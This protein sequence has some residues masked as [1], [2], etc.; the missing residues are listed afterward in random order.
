MDKGRQVG[1]DRVMTKRERNRFVPGEIRVFDCH[2]CYK[3]ALSDKKGIARE[4]SA[5]ALAAGRREYV[6]NE[7]AR[8]RRDDE[9]PP[10]NTTSW[11]NS[12][13]CTSKLN[14]RRCHESNSRHI[15]RMV[16]SHIRIIRNVFR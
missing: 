2:F 7:T 1:P 6:D 12:R 13:P 4:G 9:G 5:K 10:T 11:T 8:R 3:T 16:D 14:F 15:R